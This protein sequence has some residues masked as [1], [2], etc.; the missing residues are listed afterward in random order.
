[1]IIINVCNIRNSL[2]V[3][4]K[5]YNL[6]FIIILRSQNAIERVVQYSITF[7]YSD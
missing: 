6:F 2:F 3:G 7:Y 4:L 5:K 1:M